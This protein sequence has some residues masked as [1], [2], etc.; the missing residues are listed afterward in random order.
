MTPDHLFGRGTSGYAVDQVNAHN[1]RYL[2][3]A[4]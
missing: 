2:C 4:W 1:G 3:G